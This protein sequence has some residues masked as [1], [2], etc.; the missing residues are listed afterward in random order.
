MVDSWIRHTLLHSADINSN[1]H[2]NK[3][4]E[5][6]WNF[7]Q[8]LWDTVEPH[9]LSLYQWTSHNGAILKNTKHFSSIFRM[10]L[11]FYD[12]YVVFTCSGGGTTVFWKFIMDL[13]KLVR[14]LSR[15]ILECSMTSAQEA[16]IFFF[17]CTQSNR[18]GFLLWW[19]H[20]KSQDEKRCTVASLAQR[21][22][23]EYEY[24]RFG[25]PSH[26]CRYSWTHTRS[27][28]ALTE[29][30]SSSGSNGE[31][32]GKALENILWLKYSSSYLLMLSKQASC[33]LLPWWL[34]Y[35]PLKLF[36]WAKTWTDSVCY[37]TLY[38]I[39]L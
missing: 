34:H 21:S 36:S 10:S 7:I 27:L 35:S 11:F 33:W 12:T 25:G 28:P 26:S 5:N 39:L 30:A 2:V 22:P 18:S 13:K 15:V 24:I 3:W 31:C 1:S 6:V 32:V 29:A 17:F 19:Y 14:L 16:V 37:S 8:Q 23:W 20:H 38:R 4:S 9:F